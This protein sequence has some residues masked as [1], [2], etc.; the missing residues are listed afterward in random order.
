MEVPSSQGLDEGSFVPAVERS[1]VVEVPARMLISD[2][3]V[4]E[5]D[6]VTERMSP[7]VRL[8]KVVRRLVKWRKDAR[9]RQDDVI[10]ALQWSKAKLSRFE[11][12]EQAPGPAEILAL[13]AIY[14]V[15][16]EERDQYVAL[17]L[18]ARQKGWWQ[19]YGPNTFA[20][21]FEE[22]V[23]LE[24][25]ANHVREYASELIPGL[26]QTENYAAALMR[27]WIPAVSDSVARERADLRVQRQ[28]RLHEAK[29]VQVSAIIHES[30]LR[31]RVGGADV[32]REQLNHLVT[33]S[34]VPHV[35]TQ[36]L[37]FE[38]EAVPALGAPF[39]L[40]SF[41]DA[42]DPDVPFADYLTGC[43]YVEDPAEVE[44][45]NL[46]YSALEQKALTPADS[47]KLISKI[48]GEL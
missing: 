4:Q 38:V 27:A 30:G 19:S 9:M 3:V 42:D 29:P 15:P 11:N 45:Y 7:T 25:E 37:P 8:R 10:S 18:Q 12:A 21:N 6:S 43:V 46:N 35:T 20:S 16:D 5:E 1:N 14:G 48:A 31:Q 34:E 2:D 23:G 24:S 39:I 22:Y 13:A 36:V 28:A 40:L 17:A 41:P 44:S 26:L 47:M 33:S 32:M